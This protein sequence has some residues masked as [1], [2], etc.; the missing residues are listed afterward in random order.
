MARAAAAMESNPA[1][2]SA[3]KGGSGMS[4]SVASVTTP[5]RPS[6]PTNKPVKSNPVLFLWVRPPNRTMAPPARTTSRPRTKSRVT[7]YLRQRG[8][9]ALVAMVPPI[10]AIRPAGRIGRIVKTFLFHRVLQGLQ[11]DAGLDDRDKIAGVDFLDA[12]HAGQGE[13]NPA[14]RRD[15]S[16]NIAKARPARR[17]GDAVAAGEAQEQR[18]RIRPARQRHRVGHAGGEPF[19]AGMGLARGGVEAQL[20]RRQ[21]FLELPQGACPG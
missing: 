21:Q 1:T 2:S 7:P 14:A 6:E 19:V 4:F 5:S 15:A 18:H 10:A 9:P 16:A 13:H 8:P 3:W 20:A 12:V 17:H 11:N